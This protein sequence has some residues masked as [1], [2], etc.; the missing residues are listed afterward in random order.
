MKILSFGE[1]I[2]DVYENEKFIGG[3]PLNLAAHCS[4]QG[5]DAFMLSSVGN[6][7]LGKCA[8]N[9]VKNF[10]VKTDFVYDETIYIC[11]ATDG[12]NGG[13]LL[14]NYAEHDT[15]L[16]KDITIELKNILGESGG[17][18]KVYKLDEEHNGDLVTN[19]PY[20]GDESHTLTLHAELFTTYYVEILPNE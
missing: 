11:C 4:K 5:A 18:I 16:A 9:E 3:A 7:D 2:W 15:A 17:R 14:T 19:E 8:L 10:N 20:Q 12:K 6:D 13:I 1:I